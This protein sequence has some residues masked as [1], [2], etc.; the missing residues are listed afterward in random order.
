[1]PVKENSQILTSWLTPNW[2]APTRVRS[3]ITTRA[4]HN[5]AL[6]VGDDPET[7]LANREQ[8]AG[9]AG[10]VSQPQWLEQVHG[11]K[12]VE[13]R[14]DDRVRTADACY[15]AEP[16]VVCTVM[17]ADCLPLLICNRAG[18]RVAAVHAGWRSLAGGI[19]RDT[20]AVF[21]GAPEELLVYLGPAISQANF[22]VGIDVLEGFYE[23][24]L[25]AR[26][27]E[28]ISAACRPSLQRPMKFHADLYQLAR[29]E[30]SE[31]GVERIYGGHYCTYSDAE[32]FY[33]YRRDGQT[34]RMVS[35]I[36]LA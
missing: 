21:S 9:Q 14:A 25:S 3:L 32:R 7:V 15:T 18:T 20:L 13:A 22:E 34:G 19:V 29:A 36:W 16:G 24:A 12:V 30:L 26:H 35:A 27:C 31:L 2:P 5:M 28:A 33:S 23:G 1:M 11:T 10:W 8:L 6:H 4:N 17:T